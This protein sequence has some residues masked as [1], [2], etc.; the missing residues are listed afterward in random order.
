MATVKEIN[1]DTGPPIG[2]FYGSVTDIDGAVTVNNASA[3]GG[4]AFGVEM[5]LDAG[6]NSVILVESFTALTGTDLRWRLRLNFANVSDFGGM[7]VDFQ[8]QTTSSLVFRFFINSTVVDLQYHSDSGGTTSLGS[9]PLIKTE[10]FCLE[11]RAIRET[12]DGNADGIAEVFVNG[13]SKDLNVNLDNFIRWNLGIDKCR[14]VFQSGG[15]QAGDIYYD[16]WILDNN[17]TVNLCAGDVLTLSIIPKPASVDA[18]GTFIYVAL[19]N[20][21]TPILSKFSTALD[22]DGVTVFDPGAGDTIGVECGRF[23]DQVVWIAGLFAGT[24]QVEKSED[25]GSTFTVKNVGFDAGGVFAFDIGPDS[26]EKV[27]VNNNDTQIL[28]TTDD[29]ATWIT[30]TTT[31]IE[32]LSIDRLAKNTQET[33]FGNFGGAI[34][35]IN[36]SINSGTDIADFQTGVFPNEDVTGV[37]VN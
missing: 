6:A 4:S 26:D 9:S 3:L 5:N 1:H 32:V 37:I 31:N 28:E 27:I 35:S 20:N 23:D 21:G 7:F 10:E 24:D 13:V 17:S 22:A 33:V 11:L 12:A 2:D 30:R 8:L 25:A 36:Y 16:E 18:S 14:I 15:S 34:N 19:L 29:G